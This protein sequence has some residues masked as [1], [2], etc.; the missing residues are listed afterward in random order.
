M[1]SGS[2]PMLCYVCFLLGR[3]G[4]EYA[5]RFIVLPSNQ[6]LMRRLKELGNSH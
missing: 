5:R 6:A 4:Y 2:R 3:K 1:D